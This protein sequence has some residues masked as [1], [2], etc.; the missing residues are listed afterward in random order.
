MRLTK[1]NLRENCR[2]MS[3]PIPGD[4]VQPD[5][6]DRRD[7]SSWGRRMLGT[8][9]AITYKRDVTNT[10]YTSVLHDG[11]PLWYVRWHDGRSGFYVDHHIRRA[12]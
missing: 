4:L 6:P 12:R 3:R 1:K 8:V 9:V 7:L 5:R 11:C 10:Q 2:N